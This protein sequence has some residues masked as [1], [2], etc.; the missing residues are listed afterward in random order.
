MNRDC[1]GWLGVLYQSS[2]SVSGLSLDWAGKPNF[3]VRGTLTAGKVS[4]RALTSLAGR[5]VSWRGRGLR[6]P[7][8]LLL[9][10]WQKRW[11]GSPLG[12][13]RTAVPLRYRA[14]RYRKSGTGSPGPAAPVAAETTNATLKLAVFI[15]AWRHLLTNRGLFFSFEPSHYRWRTLFIE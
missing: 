2:I 7:A 11:S 9:R 10:G 5:G 13:S 6:T 3:C 12:A 15:A 4:A 14:T 8:S 1:H